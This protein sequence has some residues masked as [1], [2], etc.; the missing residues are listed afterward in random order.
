MRNAEFFM[1][2][3]ESKASIS[4]IIAL[5]LILI[6][7]G[8]IYFDAM[9][10]D[11]N[12][13][14]DKIIDK[15]SDYEGNKD[16]YSSELLIESSEDEKLLWPLSISKY[17]Y[18]GYP[19]IDKDGNASN[20]K[21][22]GYTGHEGTD[23]DLSLADM[24]NN[25]SVLAAL[26]GEVLWIFEGKYDL[27]PANHPDCKAPSKKDAPGLS[28]GYRVCSE[29]GDYYPYGTKIDS[30]F[31]CFDSGNVIVIKHDNNPKVFATIYGHLKNNSITIKPGDYVKKGQKIAE[32]GSAGKSSGPHLHFEVWG[33]AFYDP[34]D[35][36]AGSC[37]PNY[38]HSL[39]QNQ[40]KYQT[41]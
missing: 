40:T 4:I 3:R 36:W 13:K 39:W 11:N 10:S 41:K 27:C 29:L 18:L 5:L 8:Y 1:K 26:D 2:K 33:R 6:S 38:N 37:G 22:P 32:V 25:I 23:I 31:W 34:V 12:L 30:W 14:K 17:A 28:S 19:D 16:Y 21:L 9:Q 24:K 7:A 20:C 35:P 15:S